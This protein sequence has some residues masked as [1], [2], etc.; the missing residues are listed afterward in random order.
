MPHPKAP[1]EQTTRSHLFSGVR[2]TGGSQVIQQVLN[3]GFSVVMAR[4]LAPEDFG[5]L[6]MASVFTGV[7]FLV[8]DLGLGSA[9]IQ[10]KT[11][12][13]QQVSSIFWMNV[14]TG[15][16]MTLVGIGASWA[17]ASFYS[18]PAVQPI[19]VGLSL[20]FL[21]FSLSATQQALL[22]RQMNFQSLELRTL[23]GHL[24]GTLCGVGMAFAGFGVW[25][26]VARI[27]ITGF[28][29]MV[30]LW[31]VSG[32]RPDWYFRWADVQQLMGYSNDVLSSNFL[33]YIGRNADNFLIGR[34]VGITELGY[35]ALAYNV[36]RLPVQRFSQVLI[37]VLF[38]A[39]ARLQE[40][41]HKLK[42][43][44]FRATRLAGAVT[45]PMMLGLIVL[46]PQLVPVVYGEQWI[47][48]VP[49]LQV[50]SISGIIQAIAL[51]DGTILLAIGRS[52]LKLKITTLGITLAVTS[53][54]IGLPFGILGV[55]TCFVIANAFTSA[56][57]LYLALRCVG[58]NYLDY[59]RNLAGVLA[60]CG[61]MT[62]IV[63]SIAIFA[64]L[65]AGLTLAIAIP[66]GAIAYLIL[67]RL[68]APATFT[69][70][71]GILPN[72]LTRRW[73]KPA[74]TK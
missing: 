71:L 46:A 40:D 36:M 7:V 26:L 55:A 25:S 62:L 10:R 69:E 58:S 38:P 22:T 37:R 48:V 17:I 61:G 35:Y 41:I 57:S 13:E 29:G 18:T 12:T 67:L 43:G 44:W 32:W 53:F 72:R 49:V 2:W 14:F 68:C 52:R 74:K 73:S 63:L 6:A 50:L 8:L 42:H 15:V 21:V 56:L 47:P 28:V 54:I 51:L 64:P 39:M 4:L 31:S 65:T 5:L 9:L 16:V 19:V 11:I 70:G 59:F 30:L 23:G 34:F 45:L 20:N 60:A 1:A 24:V 3:L 66:T 27:V 33:N